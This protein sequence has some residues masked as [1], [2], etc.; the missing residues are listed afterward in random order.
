[1]DTATTTRTATT[2]LVSA[3]DEEGLR[4]AAAAI[5]SAQTVD[6][7]ALAAL[8]RL[9]HRAAV[10]A[11]GPDAAR[12]AMADVAADAFSP[13]A[14]RGV[15]DTGPVGAL[16]TGQGSQRPGMGRELAQL[17]PDFGDALR[18]VC[19]AL[20]AE[21]PRPLLP[22]VFS[23]PG[24][25]EAEA[26]G[27]TEFTQPALFAVEVALFR[28][29]ES[30]GLRPAALLGHSI[31]ELSAAHVAGV[32]DLADAAA[33]IA[34]RG[35]LMQS[36]RP[37]GAMIAIAAPEDAVLPH[38]VPGVGIAA[39]N[40][41]KAVVI[42]GD[43]GSAAEV[44]AA[45][46]ADGHK[47]TPLRVGR[48]FHSSHMDP[49]LDEFHAVVSSVELHEPRIPVVSN[50]TGRV[51]NDLTD[52]AYWVSHLRSAVRFAD[53]VRT[54]TNDGVRTFVE[55]GPDPTLSALGRTCAPDAVF[56]HTLRRRTPEHATVLGAAAALWV[57][58]SELDWSR[59]LD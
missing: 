45:L 17:V 38:L 10:T 11:V 3:R 30:W 9:P 54:M 31:G 4:A 6:P 18:D 1:M 13:D 21:L 34:A 2:W 56:V 48:A 42:S 15:A 23:E 58:G 32:F 51:A 22:L 52:P 59:I 25:P 20:D 53:G 47:T 57:R 49:V 44:A 7:R 37:D 35:R 29:F 43:A 19:A 33:V 5:A 55:F 16:F 50:V 12:A 28:V 26:L 14:V 46:A 41:P 40:G 8:P 36:A 39:V 24:S 27:T